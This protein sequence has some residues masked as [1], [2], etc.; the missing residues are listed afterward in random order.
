M[1]SMLLCVLTGAALIYVPMVSGCESGTVSTDLPGTNTGTGSGGGGT[2]GAGGHTSSAPPT[3]QLTPGVVGRVTSQNYAMDVQV[4]HPI[5]HKP[6]SGGD[7]K[8][9]VATPIKP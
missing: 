3:V 6:V 4:G 7:K 1:K 9:E 2:G 8:I 5:A